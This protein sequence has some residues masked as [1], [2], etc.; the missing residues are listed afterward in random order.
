MNIGR[1]KAMAGI[2][3][4]REQVK[5][6]E[7]EVAEAQEELETFKAANNGSLEAIRDEFEDYKQHPL[8]QEYSEKTSQY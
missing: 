6:Y 3:E 8:W 4:A 7:Q 5:A 2:E 1:S